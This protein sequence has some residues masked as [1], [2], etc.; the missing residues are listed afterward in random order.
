MSHSH[1]HTHGFCFRPHQQRNG[2]SEFLKGKESR[3]GKKGKKRRRGGRGQRSLSGT[4]H[5][6]AGSLIPPPNPHT[7]AKAWLLSSSTCSPHRMLNSLAC[8]SLC[9]H[10]QG[11]RPLPLLLAATPHST[12]QLD[13]LPELSSDLSSF[14]E[15]SL[16][17]EVW[18]TRPMAHPSLH[19]LGYAVR[20]QDCHG[21][22]ARVCLKKRHKTETETKPQASAW[23]T[24]ALN[25][26]HPVLGVPQGP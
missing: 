22:I 14:A 10:A 25:K 21:Y 26:H 8:L 19:S 4:S 24:R 15:W 3:G 5:H 12:R 2:N 9:S 11:A 6:T 1:C 20:V 23:H 18:L 13:N 16:V 7:E 17:S